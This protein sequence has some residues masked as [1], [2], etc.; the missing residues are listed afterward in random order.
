MDFMHTLGNAAM[1]AFIT[2]NSS[3]KSTQFWI[4]VRLFQATVFLVSAFIY[5]GEQRRW[6]SK[7]IL[8]SAALLVPG[9]VFV[10]IT[11]F[12]SAVPD[13]FVQGAGLTPFK[14]YSEYLVVGL[15]CLSLAA[16]WRRMERSGSRLLLYYLAA[17]IISIF[18]EICFA[19]YTRVFDTYN[20]VGHIYKVAAFSLI[21]KGIFIASV[22]DPYIKLAEGEHARHLASFPELNPNPV[23]EIASSGKITF[24]NPATEKTLAN[25]GMDKNDPSVFLPNDIE[26]I[27]RDLEKKKESAL[28]REITLKDRVFGQ[29]IYLTPQ[30]NVGEGICKR[31]HRTQAGGRGTVP[32]FL[33]SGIFTGRDF[34][35]EN[36]RCSPHLEQRR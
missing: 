28:Y 29:A 27:L 5:S 6:L 34:Q 12:P 3:N 4:A 13:T 15:L 33:V 36:G 1:P 9:A 21:Y 16:Y 26:D 32:A 30:F 24:F 10:G 11:F 20:V 17:L 19:V 14:K 8:L 23:L 7:R 25:L 31:Y 18:S 35:Y 2:P 22:K